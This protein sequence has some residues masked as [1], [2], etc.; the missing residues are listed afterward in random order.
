MSSKTYF[1]TVAGAWDSMRQGFF[2]EAV[3]DRALTVA[4]VRAGERAADLGAGSG[5]LTE[6][7]LATGLDVI[8]VDQSPAMLD[9]MRAKFGPDAADYRVG[10]AEALPVEDS[11]VDHAFANMFL[12]HVDDPAAAIREMARIL[13]PGGRLVITDLDAHD[14]TF[15]LEEHHDHWPGFR[16]ADVQAW[17]EAAGLDAVTVEDAECSCCAE[18]ACGCQKASVS[19]FLAKGVKG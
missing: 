5:F 3:R 4:G 13:R 8:A 16:R 10:T 6:A 7:L 1:D 11:S 2:S 14:F 12:H 9:V 19:I 15:L 17:F 18:S